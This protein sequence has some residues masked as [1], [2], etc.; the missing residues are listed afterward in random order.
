MKIN[1]VS[2]SK[3]KEKLELLRRAATMLEAL[4]KMKIDD[5]LKAELKDPKMKKLY[6]LTGKATQTQLVK[7]TG[8]SAG[9]ISGI[10]KKWERKGILKKVGKI[11]KKIF[12]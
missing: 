9:K 2:D 8:F 4:V 7:Q 12:E 3:E 11:Y 6:D 1:K 10:W 5:V